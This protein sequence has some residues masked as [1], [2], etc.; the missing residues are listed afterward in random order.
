M[1]MI[2]QTMIWDYLMVLSIEI[3]IKIINRNLNIGQT[4]NFNNKNEYLDKL[5]MMGSFLIILLI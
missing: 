2:N 1:D 4:Y 5:K 3:G